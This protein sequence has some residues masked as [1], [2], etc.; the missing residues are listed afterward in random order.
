MAGRN[1]G[2]VRASRDYCALRACHARRGITAR[3]DRL[4]IVKFNDLPVVHIYAAQIAT[5][6]PLPRSKFHGG[7]ETN[8]RLKNLGFDT[9]PKSPGL[10]RHPRTSFH[11]QPEAQHP[12]SL[13]VHKN[14]GRLLHLS[15]VKQTRISTALMSLIDPPSEEDFPLPFRSVR[16]DQPASA[17]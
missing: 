15:G 3:P 10:R 12:K 1:M 2:L 6:T 13:A 7:P 11:H 17:R 4:G 5:G 8:D 16:Q 14:A 9:Q